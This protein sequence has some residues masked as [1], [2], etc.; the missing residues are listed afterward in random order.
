[1]EITSGEDRERR[2][3]GG[4]PH[5]VRHAQQEDDADGEGDSEVAIPALT[6]A[7][8]YRYRCQVELSLKWDS[9]CFTSL[10]A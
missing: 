3:D 8:L 9:Q 1:M 4:A 6:V 10:C 5:R 7:E 2:D